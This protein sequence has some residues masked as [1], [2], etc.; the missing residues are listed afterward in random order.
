MNNTPRFVSVERD[1][2]GS[3]ANDLRNLQG[4]PT[5]IH[6]MIQNADDVKD[7]EGRPGGATKISFD[8]GDD[9]L[10]VENDGLFST[11]ENIGAETCSWQRQKGRLC[12]VHR[13]RV[14]AGGDKRKE[15]DTTGAFGIGFT[16]VYQVTDHP[17]VIT[18]KHHLTF[19]PEQPSD[20]RLE[21]RETLAYRGTL[22]V[23][24]WAFNQH[25]PVREK[26]SVPAIQP[27]QL[28]EFQ[29]EIE[30]SL[31]LAALFLK[32]LRFLE[33]RRNGRILLRVERRHLDRNRVELEANGRRQ[34]WHL[35]DGTFDAEAQRIR[36]QFPGR[37]EPKRH[38]NVQ[39]AVGD[40]V[41]DAGRLFAV[42]PTQR[43]MP[44]PFH[45]NADFFPTADRKDIILERDFQSA[46]NRAAI[47]AAART[48][49]RNFNGLCSLM[50]HRALWGFIHKIE[51]SVGVI[52]GQNLDP[53]F[54]HFWQVIEPLLKDSR[55]VFTTDDRWVKP[56]EARL[57]ETDDER[58]AEAIFGALGI[59]IVHR[60]LRPYHNLLLG[61][62][63]GVPLLTVKDVATALRQVGLTKPHTLDEVPSTLRTREQWH[64]LWRALD[65]LLA[66]RSK[67]DISSLQSVAIAFGSDGSLWP[68]GQLFRGDRDARRLFPGVK[69]LDTP[70]GM[71]KVP[72]RFVPE[73][74][75]VSAIDILEQMGSAAIDAAWKDD[76]VTLEA[77]YSW[78][79]TRRLEVIDNSILKER[80]R[81]L[82]IWPVAGQLRRLPGLFLPSGFT[83]PLHLSSFV[84]VAALGG[85]VDFLRDLG[86]E[87]LTLS[88]YVRDQVPQALKYSRSP[89]RFG[90]LLELLAQH[91]SVF[92][93]DTIARNRLSGLP[94]VA[95]SDGVHRVARYVYAL[96]N[97]RELLGERYY[98]AD[99]PNE[100]V[101]A[102]HRWLG[103]ETDLRPT[104]VLQRVKEMTT[105][106]PTAHS[107][108]TIQA[109]FRYLT[110]RWN[111][112]DENERSLY[113]EL[114]SIAWLPG[115][116]HSTRWFRPDEIYTT[117]LDYLFESQGEFLA[118]PRNLQTAGAS[119][120]EFLG[121]KDA[122]EPSL[123]VKHLLAYVDRNKEVNREVYVF[124][125]RHTEDRSLDA[126]VHAAC[127]HMGEGRYVYPDRVFIDENPFHLWR[128]R[129][130]NELKSLDALL[131]RLHVRPEPTYQDHI[132]VLLE[133]AGTTTN[134]DEG[135]HNVVMRCWQKLSTGLVDEEISVDDIATLQDQK[136][137]PDKQNRLRYPRY[138]F[139]ADRAGLAERFRQDLQN[140]VIVR[141][142]GTWQAMQAAG[143]RPLGAAVTVHAVECT[144]PRVADD[145]MNRL[146]ERRHLVDR[147][148]ESERAKGNNGLDRTM[149]DHPRIKRART[150]QVRWELAETGS[151]TPPEYV[152][153]ILMPD[154]NSGNAPTIF[155]AHEHGHQPWAPLARELAYAINP[156]FEIGALAGGI[157][158]VLASESTAAAEATLNEL[159]YPP[160]QYWMD[161]REDTLDSISLA[162]TTP[163]IEAYSKDD[164]VAEDSRTDADVQGIGTFDDVGLGA[165]RA[166]GQSE[167]SVTPH[168]PTPDL[169]SHDRIDPP[170]AG[171]TSFTAEKE[172][173]RTDP[174][175]TSTTPL[176]PVKPTVSQGPTTKQELP[177]RN[178]GRLITYVEHGPN[179]EDDDIATLVEDES[180][181]DVAKE[182][183]KVDLAGIE[184]VVQSEEDS[185]R[186]VERR[187]HHQ[188]GYD[189]ISRDRSGAIR[190]IEVKSLKGYWSQHSPAALSRAQFEMARTEGE[191]YWLYVVERATS[192]DCQIYRIQNPA[193]LVDAYL[194]D[195]GW[196]GVAVVSKQDQ[197]QDISES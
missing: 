88:T 141:S 191:N 53:V 31:A 188:K 159:G 151:T 2:L 33:L 98:V 146:R 115:S 52:A 150:L 29:H 97:V 58:M 45:I 110:T 108:H 38:A 152:Q 190:Y 171:M 62:A 24:P 22:F 21:I 35:F 50:G 10:R 155:V 177:N 68:P 116:S 5:L 149:L 194:F 172:R 14:V 144:D 60:E 174:G 164:G 147:I 169:H 76:R 158:E 75:A 93:A 43:V 41:L 134:L 189:L 192:H 125:N 90:P 111:N 187:P 71:D 101:A 166:D 175:T 51:Q 148:L 176:S 81:R 91:L 59:S 39:I 122:P 181:Y 47:A 95:C 64:L 184:H 103:V 183:S 48:L 165:S 92:A 27:H 99:A 119:L 16:A 100:S 162:T 40:T 167:E 11:C 67:T 34:I 84:D 55:I 18:G 32:Y 156:G 78:F 138:L 129:L 4:I 74:T 7:R 96:G 118:F 113:R 19:R 13:L 133:I 139:F 49:G 161:T 106:P 120:L 121:L 178:N 46:W 69:W 73:F 1:F 124:L 57:L 12:D 15:A 30:G 9:A 128:D 112:L 80:L 154:R 143:V 114:K 157:K 140:N 173:P 170:D 145:L 89:E 196:R 23:L 56:A 20:R 77:L 135:T 54:K 85:R 17:E 160:L 107:L 180:D 186:E 42:L 25:S 117:F 131:R 94:L 28:D 163:T 65:A 8:I 105:A 61:Q 63:V 168:R 37:I 126:L 86:V 6:E 87:V 82:P 185:D 136:V 66:R 123:V 70:Q 3:M 109:L 130:P 83:D 26:L 72:D 197:V 179:G 195:Y 79:E 102:L 193:K 142:P 104:D 182:R 44:L 153:A 132:D 137:V 36:E 127:I